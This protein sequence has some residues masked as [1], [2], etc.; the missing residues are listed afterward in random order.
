MSSDW[1]PY[2]TSGVCTIRL[3]AGNRLLLNKF[4][5]SLS[6]V[7]PCYWVAHAEY[8]VCKTYGLLYLPTTLNSLGSVS[9]NQKL[10]FI[11]CAIVW[12]NLLLK[13]LLVLNAKH[14]L[15]VVGWSF[16]SLLHLVVFIGVGL[17]LDCLV[18]YGLDLSVCAPQLIKYDFPFSL[19]LEEFQALW[20]IALVAFGASGDL[21]PSGNWLNSVI[22]LVWENCGRME[23]V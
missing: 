3:W 20:R 23:F 4:I 6:C 21:S 13:L 19:F 16:H 12:Y 17:S 5:S 1:Y 11:M 9:F 14:I 18:G 7:F 10:Y 8:K 2:D 15:I 22:S